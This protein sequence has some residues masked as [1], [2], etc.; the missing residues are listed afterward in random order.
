M[1]KQLRRHL[2]DTSISEAIYGSYLSK[3][4]NFTHFGALRY[5][6]KL[7]EMMP[8]WRVLHGKQMDYQFCLPFF[9]FAAM[10]DSGRRHEGMLKILGGGLIFTQFQ[11][12]I[13]YI[14]NQ[15]NLTSQWKNPADNTFTM[16][17]RLTP[18]KLGQ[19]DILWCYALR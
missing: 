11:S 17:S 5:T 7:A 13:S 4:C 12:V 3:W 18:L 16:M 2:M 15:K 19:T 14:I 8:R 1:G 9:L 6:P 10:I